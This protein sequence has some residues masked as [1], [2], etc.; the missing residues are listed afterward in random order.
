MSINPISPNLSASIQ[1]LANHLHVSGAQLPGITINPSIT[2]LAG[3]NTRIA[4]ALMITLAQLRGPHRGY[5]ASY[6]NS[7]SLD[8][9]QFNKVFLLALMEA[10]NFEH[11]KAGVNTSFPF[12]QDVIKTEYT[13]FHHPQAQTLL[14]DV[15]LELIDDIH[16]M[17]KSKSKSNSPIHDL[18]IAARNLLQEAD[19]PSDDHA[20]IDLLTRIEKLVI[21]SSSSGNFIDSTA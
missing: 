9:S 14:E 15:L 5:S 13:P 1:S 4:K 8:S 3:T 12:G 17:H 10:L 21:G 11:Q 7:T 6:L 20:I 16:A 18:E 2:G 19:M